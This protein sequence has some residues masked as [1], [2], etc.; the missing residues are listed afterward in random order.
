M[1]F[2]VSFLLAGISEIAVLPARELSFREFASYFAYLFLNTKAVKKCPSCVYLFFHFKQGTGGKKR[3]EDK[4]REEKRRE[5]KRR[6]EKRR[7]GKGREG[8]GR[9]GKGR[10]EKRRAEKRRA[11][12]NTALRPFPCSPPSLNALPVPLLRQV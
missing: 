3:R 8:K 9:E 1:F 6:E 11:E 12:A 2:A 10:E 5:E 7:E 4:R